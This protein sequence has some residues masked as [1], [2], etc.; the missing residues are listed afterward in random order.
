MATVIPLLTWKEDHSILVEELDQQHRRLFDFVNR[1]QQ[2]LTSGEG[3]AG[4]CCLLDDLSRNATFHFLS[5]EA[6]MLRHEYP[7]LAGHQQEHRNLKQALEAFR[8]QI[9]QSGAGGT[10]HAYSFLP[11]WLE[12]HILC[13]DQ[14]YCT[15]LKR[16][17]QAGA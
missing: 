2:A 6:M 16:R 11:H 3:R 1:F 14:Q 10:P 8:R 5:E 17:L 4:L 13:A 9:E 7:R 12:T 15:Y